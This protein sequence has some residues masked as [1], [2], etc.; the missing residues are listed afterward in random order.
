MIKEKGRAGWYRATP[1]DS[2][3]TR[4]FTVITSRAEAVIITLALWV[5][6]LMC[7]AKR[8]DY[9]EGEHYE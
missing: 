8:I 4:Y 3:C 2:K 5:W 1:K 7:L 6:F 9:R